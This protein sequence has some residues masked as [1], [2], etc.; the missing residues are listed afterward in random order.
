MCFISASGRLNPY[1]SL[2]CSPVYRPA[3]SWHGSKFYSC[4]LPIMLK[5]WRKQLKLPELPVLVVELSAFCNEYDDHTFLTHCDQK[6]SRLSTPNTHLP[7]LRLAQ[8][9]AEEQLENVYM[10]SAQDLG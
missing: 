8:S 1:L 9:S 5:D 10:F 2:V 3:D 6:K 7:A 4:Q